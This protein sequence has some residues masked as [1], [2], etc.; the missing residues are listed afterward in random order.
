[1]VTCAS[2]TLSLNPFDSAA[3]FPTGSTFASFIASLSS[4]RAPAMAGARQLLR[5]AM[6]DA[7]VEPVGK[8]AAESNGFKDNVDDAHVTISHPPLS[9]PFTGNNDF[10]VALLSRPRPTI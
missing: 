2:S 9:G 6:N 7:N 3:F 1:M 4:C 8:N 5:D 10:V